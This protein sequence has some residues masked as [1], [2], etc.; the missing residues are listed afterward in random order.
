MRSS[1][2]PENGKKYWLIKQCNIITLVKTLSD[3]LHDDYNACTLFDDTFRVFVEVCDI[4]PL[5]RANSFGADEVAYSL[6]FTV[7]LRES[8]IEVSLPVDF[9]TVHLQIHRGEVGVQNRWN[10]SCMF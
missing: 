5:I 2:V 1:P 10:T 6:F 4:V 7:D 3:T 9:V 8:P